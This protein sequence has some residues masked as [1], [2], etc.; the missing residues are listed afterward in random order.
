MSYAAENVGAARV[1]SPNSTYFVAILNVRAAKPIKISFKA[2]DDQ[3]KRTA[4]G[5]TSI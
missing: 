2:N 1:Q 3:T 4:H 5:T